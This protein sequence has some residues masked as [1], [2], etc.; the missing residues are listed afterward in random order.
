[1]DCLQRFTT[2]DVLNKYKSDCILISGNQ[3]IKVPKIENRT[4]KFNI[5][6]Q[7]FPVPF[8]IYTDFEA[9]TEKIQTCTPRTE[10]I[11][12]RSMSLTHRL[13]IWL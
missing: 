3:A 9:I 8:A 7:Q 5:F 10:S 12:H 1:M 2:E 4:S 13:G 11:I 6:I